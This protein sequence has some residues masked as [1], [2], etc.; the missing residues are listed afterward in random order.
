MRIVAVADTHTFQD[1][2]DTVPDGDVFVHAGDLLCSGSLSELV[3]VA[4]WLRRLPHRTKIVVAGNH[5]WCFARERSEARRTLGR[6]VIYLEDTGVDVDGVT[7]W[8][9]PWQPEFCGWAFNLPRGEALRARWAHIPHRVSVLVTHGP[10]RGFGDRTFAGPTG[11]DDLLAA[12]RRAQPALN[13]FGHIHEDGGFWRDGA[14]A[15]ANVTTW[16]CARGPTVVDFDPSTR[17]VSP[18]SIP[19]ASASDD[20][21]EN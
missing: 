2:L 17:V 1:E 11:C 16:D 19:I 8:G 14:V 5:D 18:V 10:P 3:P 13:L 7:F 15:L 12:I 21:E 20:F 9:S 4:E 6:N